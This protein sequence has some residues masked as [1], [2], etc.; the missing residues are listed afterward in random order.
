MKNG[1]KFLSV[2]LAVLMLMS[3]VPMSDMGI[4]A[5]A[6]SERTTAPSSSNSCYYGSANGYSVGQCTWYAFGRAYEI[7][8]WAPNFGSGNANKWYSNNV[9]SGNFKYGSTPKV[10]SIMVTQKTSTSG[11]VA[12]VERLNSDGTMLISEYNWDV[13]L[14][15]GTKT[16]SQ[17]ATTRGSHT[18]LGYIYLLDSSD[19]G[20]SSEPIITTI[21]FNPE[22]EQQEA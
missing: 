3:I 13:S 6:F 15:F 19:S 20:S 16:L 18:V 10:G 5:S 21:T 14:G 4:E 1:K 2:F 17:S 12:V 11:H 9:S 22:V 8:G 7:L